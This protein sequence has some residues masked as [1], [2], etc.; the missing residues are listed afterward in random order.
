[1]RENAS[2]FLA[3]SVLCMC[4]P[5]QDVPGK[6][7]QLSKVLLGTEMDKALVSVCVGQ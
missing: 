5:L 3:S 4:V 2:G 1:M 6:K 7:N